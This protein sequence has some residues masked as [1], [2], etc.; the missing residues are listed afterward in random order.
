MTRYTI[1]T[2]PQASSTPGK[3]Q[4][5]GARLLWLALVFALEL[6]GIS[7]WLDAAALSRGY[8]LTRWMHN[9]GAWSLRGIVA[10]AFLFLIFAYLRNRSV[11]ARL[12]R[13]EVGARVHFAPLLVHVLLLAAFARFA[14]PLFRSQP[15]GPSANAFAVGFLVSGLAAIAAAALAFLPLPAWGRLLRG[16][17]EMWM[18]ACAGAILTCWLGSQLRSLWSPLARA[19]FAIVRVLLRPFLSAVV[20]DPATQ[21]LGSPS[22]QVTIEPTCSGLEG[23]GLMLI[24]TLVWLWLCRRE[25]RFPR[26]LLLVPVSLAA[27]F[28]LNSVRIAALILIGSAGAPNLAMGGF[29]SQ[30][31]W[32]GFNL[33]AIGLAIGSRRAGWITRGKRE[34][35][36]GSLFADNASAVYL[37]PF[38]AILAAGMLSRAVAS[39]FEWLY[40][41][42]I[43]AA[44]AVLWCYRRH[45]RQLD[46]R[47][48]WLA[49]AVGGG[50]F[51]LWIAADR[52]FGRRAA[53]PGIVPMHG[54][55]W[56]A[57]L[58]LRVAGAVVTVPIA[59]EL[60]FRGYLL[61]RVDSA[62]FENVSFRAVSLPALAI[63]SA[64]FG[65][66]HGSR[67]MA[68]SV[69]GLAYALAAR[70]RA[71]IGEAVAAHAVT[72]ALLAF[73]VIA[74]GEWGLW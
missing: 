7:V 72:N 59:E 24:F 28:A 70:R 42:R 40:P 48:G 13:E 43:V 47:C 10:F 16:S 26:A 35:A 62:A 19:T 38:A 61:R 33:I 6:T 29:H 8:F 5:I 46:W 9:W 63:S 12:F 56:I 67:W 64:A 27:A 23:M 74:R 50:V 17:G 31:G 11:I 4:S 18:Y 21:N 3:S 65:I 25:F 52:L 51:V 15:M 41:L 58:V 30:A 60:A 49:A 69:A 22:F 44:A 54:A 45:Y 71:R 34:A 20:A 39:P 66:M 73:W 53:G 1:S 36:R 68:G 2:L 55:A 32:I 14:Q 57:W 37:G